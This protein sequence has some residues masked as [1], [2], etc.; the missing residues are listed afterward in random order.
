MIAISQTANLSAFD[1][2][3]VR[4]YADAVRR[5]EAVWCREPLADVL[6]KLNLIAAKPA[7]QQARQRTYAGSGSTAVIGVPGLR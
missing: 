6:C 2:D 4:R 7:S 3:A 5:K 1:A